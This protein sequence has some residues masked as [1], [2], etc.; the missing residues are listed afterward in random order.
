MAA[1]RWPKARPFKKPDWFNLRLLLVGLLFFLTGC[2]GYREVDDSA[3]VLI[4]GVDKGKEN[5]LALTAQIAVPRAMG[6][7]SMGGGGGDGGGGGGQRST[8][9]IT[10]ESRT[11]LTGLD[12][13][14]ATVERRIY[15]KHLKLLVFSKE[16]AEQG[17]EPH[18]TSLMRF[19]EFRRN[20]FMAISQGSSRELVEH[21]KPIM[22]ANPAEY[23]EKLITSQEYVGFTPFGQLHHFYS[24][25]KSVSI[26]A[27]APLVALKER[28]GKRSGLPAGVE[29]SAYLAGQLPRKG[30][31]DVE[32][33]GTAVFKGDRLV[34]ELTGEETVILNMLKGQF[35]QSQLA[36]PDP[37]DPDRFVTIRLLGERKPQLNVVMG[38]DGVPDVSARVSL[39]AEITGIQSGVTYERPDKIPVLE[40]EINRILE[41]KAAELIRKSQE[42]FGADIFG[43]GFKARRLAATWHQWLEMKWLELYP[44]ARVTVTFKTH[45]RR[46]GLLREPSPVRR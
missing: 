9:T 21:I 30:G 15:L 6:A 38:K 43:F 41:E 3:Y 25:I 7:G 32:Q 35:K 13:M 20:N 46:I 34:G 14:N 24:D 42:E 11:I 26:Q 18:V 5:A 37:A 16:L 31:G 40:M 27:T 33:I 44:Q 36:F 39:E 8:M 4:L 29:E 19:P 10:V 22:E 45:I 1:I 23:V 17:L 12:M 28:E 2:W